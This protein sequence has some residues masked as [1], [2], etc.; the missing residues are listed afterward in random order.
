MR[1]YPSRVRLAGHH[2]G[3]HIR[4]RAKRKPVNPD[5]E[6]RRDLSPVQMVRL[7][8]LGGMVG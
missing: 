6:R 4:I 8:Q 2:S 3:V 1:C 7:V 5:A